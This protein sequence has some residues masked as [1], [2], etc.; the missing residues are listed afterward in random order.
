[1][2]SGHLNK[3][4]K[5]QCFLEREGLLILLLVTVTAK[6]LTRE[7]ALCDREQ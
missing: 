4:E 2:A 7:V 3:L 6:Q 1:M 5:C